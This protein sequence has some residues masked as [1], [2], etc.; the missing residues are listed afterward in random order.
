MEN[1]ATGLLETF[2]YTC[3]MVCA[4]A[5]AKA[6]DVEIVAIDHNRP[7]AHIK[8]D[9]PVVVCV[10]M[11]G[12]VAAVEAGMEAAIRVAKSKNGVLTSHIISRPTD[13]AEKLIERCSVGRD[14]IKK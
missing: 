7:A 12:T 4:D 6:A 3:A 2:G 5:A 14:R 11:Q 1:K 10:K 13:D 8:T 9:V